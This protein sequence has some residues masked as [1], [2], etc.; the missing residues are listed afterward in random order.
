MS[1][2]LLYDY[3]RSS[4]AYRVRIALNVKGVA[5]TSIPVNLAD[6]AQKTPEYRARNPQGSVPMLSINGHDLT[7]SLAIIDYLDS[8]YPEPKMV[9]GDPV[10]RAKTLAQALLIAA[11]I[12]PLNNLRV[13]HYLKG[14][15][16]QDQ[17]AIDDWYRHW[18]NEGFTALETM[19]PENGMF[20]GDLPNL[21]DVCLVPQM[22]NARRFD[23]PL[24][25][26]PKLLRIDA[27]L[28]AL[29][30]FVA[31]APEAVQP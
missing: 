5:H 17:A 7:Q 25:A 14:P 29:P 27:T 21:S 28:R 13:L 31:A 26:F 6:G 22:A 15:M 8:Q 10:A 11:D 18:I 2:I 23:A 24:E 1:E 3:W 4:A 20:G 19:A 16:G 12:H 30:A 9:P